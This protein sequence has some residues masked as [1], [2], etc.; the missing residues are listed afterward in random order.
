[1]EV[2][3]VHE[4]PS[5]SVLPAVILGALLLLALHWNRTR[6]SAPALRVLADVAVLAP[7]LMALAW[8]GVW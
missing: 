4:D 2:W 5:L 6:F 1:V 7:A 3:F 8:R